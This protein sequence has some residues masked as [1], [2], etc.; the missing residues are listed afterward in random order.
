MAAADHLSGPQFMSV[1]ELGSYQSSDYPDK[2]ADQTHA[3]L[4][5][6]MNQ[7]DFVNVRQHNLIR[8]VRDNG[9]Q[10]PIE[11]DPESRMLV[12]GHHRFSAAKSLRMKEVPVKHKKYDA[13]DDYAD[14]D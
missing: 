1:K 7:V 5:R 11:V 9:M 8:D 2:T 6:A 3:H 10:N 14:W 12:H 13:A 4:R